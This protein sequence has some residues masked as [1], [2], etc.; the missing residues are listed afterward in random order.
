MR[1]RVVAR[2]VARVGTRHRGEA[3]RNMVIRVVGDDGD[4][5]YA[6]DAGD[7]GDLEYFTYGCPVKGCSA[8]TRLSCLEARQRERWQGWVV[9]F[10]VGGCL[11][12]CNYDPS[13]WSVPLLIDFDLNK[14]LE[15]L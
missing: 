14:C 15:R 5:D 13:Y 12:L 9:M 3:A 11:I 6:G 10:N 8:Q 7:G 4:G 1:A 2:V